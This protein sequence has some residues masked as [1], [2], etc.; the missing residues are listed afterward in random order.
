MFV[1]TIYSSLCSLSIC[2]DQSVPDLN[3]R[4]Q[5]NAAANNNNAP[6]PPPRDDRAYFGAAAGLWG[7]EIPEDTDAAEDA[8]DGQEQG[9]EEEAEE[10]GG[11]SDLDDDDSLDEKAPTNDNLSHEFASISITGKKNRITYNAAESDNGHILHNPKISEMD[12][13]KVAIFSIWLPSQYTEGT[14]NPYIMRGGRQVVIELKTDPSWLTP[15]AIAMS[16]AAVDGTIVGEMC[17]GYLREIQ[18]IFQTKPG[19][20]VK[21]LV[22]NIPFVAEEDFCKEL[23]DDPRF[24]GHGYCLADMRNENGESGYQMT[25]CIIEVKGDEHKKTTAATKQTINIRQER[26]RVEE[27]EREQQ[28]FQRERADF[29]CYQQ[30]NRQQR[31]QANQAN[32]EAEAA[33]SAQRNQDHYVGSDDETME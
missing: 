24:T 23:L 29:V 12:N 10:E 27:R 26:E 15:M 30:H 16:A 2:L 32:R 4:R 31:V 14:I 8:E 11:N 13:R 21:K 19:K 1:D 5:A 17:K 3:L 6:P 22:F 20:L 25:C 18:N 7:E 33:R 28:K 9:A